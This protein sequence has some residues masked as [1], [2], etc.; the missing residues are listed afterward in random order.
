MSFGDD[1]RDTEPPAAV[2]T[3][4]VYRCRRCDA[5]LAE[6]HA[7]PEVALRR[8]VEAGELATIHR[9]DDGASG[10]AMLIGTGAGRSREERQGLTE[11]PAGL[12]LE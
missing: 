9:C 3:A 6:Q 2:T 8:A 4:L 11:G 5:T 7:D 12:V 10:C 1:L